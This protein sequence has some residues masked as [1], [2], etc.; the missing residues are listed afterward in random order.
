MVG[1]TQV[2]AQLVKLFNDKIVI[3]GLPLIPG[4]LL[5]NISR[6][7]FSTMEIDIG[8]RKSVKF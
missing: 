8:K 5:R 1:G 2:K 3:Y 6:T 4:E 7:Y